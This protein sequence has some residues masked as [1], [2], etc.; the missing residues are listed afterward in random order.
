MTKG[1][2]RPT[3]TGRPQHHDASQSNRAGRQPL[4]VTRAV[5]WFL[6]FQYVL[7]LIERLGPLPWPGTLPWTEL[8]DCDP[9]KLAAVL[10][11]GVLW[12]LHED[13]RQDAMRQGGGDISRAADWSDFAR[14][15][16]QRRGVYI[17]RCAS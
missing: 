6:V 2:S 16:V 17:P 13:T 14:R 8:P 5:D 9:R 4:T 15:M 11:A 10:L 3:P 7:P 1:K 12:T